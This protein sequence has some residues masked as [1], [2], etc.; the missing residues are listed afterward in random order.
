M[1]PHDPAQI[2][3]RLLVDH[4]G[5]DLA[6]HVAGVLAHEG[7]PQ[8]LV[9][10]GV[11]H[12]L[13]EAAAGV[14]NDGAGVAEHG[15][16][17]RHGRDPLLL[18]L[19]LGDAHH[20]DLR[21][22]VDAAGD[23]VQIHVIGHAAHALHAG[24]ALCRGHMGQ[25]HHGGRVAD[26]VHAGDTGPVVL[27]H[28]QALATARRGH[29][30]GEH[31]V[32]IGA[33]ADGAQHLFAGD[34]LFRALLQQVDAQAVAGLLQRLHHGVGQHLHALLFQDLLE[35]L[36]Q[37]TVH[38]GQQAVHALHQRDGA[39]QIAVEG[40]ELHADDAAADDDQRVIEPVAALQQLVGGH[41]AGQLQP[42]DGRPHVDGAGGDEDALRGIARH[43]A[44]RRRHIHFAGGGDAAHALD[45][46]H[47]GGLQQAVDAA[48]QLLGHAALVGEDLLHIEGSACRVN[49]HARAV[50][51]VT[52]DLGGVEQRLGGD[53]APVQ[54]GAAYL[55]A[56]HHGRMQAQ[57]RGPEG[58]GIAA[59]AGAD[60][61]QLIVHAHSSGC[62]RSTG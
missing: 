4:G 28:Q 41:N 38:V 53:A 26:G 6:D 39:A 47:L 8:N 10:L 34:G 44:V 54:T 15:A 33:A 11:G 25:L 13:H 43:P 50:H 48:A 56:L 57:R 62:Q 24:G 52:I 30:L 58:G 49:A 5:A 45:E 55:T 21:R 59:G 2:L 3:H 17:A 46:V 14:L 61:D 32:P 35:V 22:A 23:H 36:A 9:G 60:H 20:G 18:G 37:L 29:A 12:Q 19:R 40:G 51:R 27:V 7:R 16:F 1:G 42:G 31:A